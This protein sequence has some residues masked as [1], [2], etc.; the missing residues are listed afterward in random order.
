MSIDRNALDKRDYLLRTNEKLLEDCGCSS[1]QEVE[2]LMARHVKQLNLYN[3][4]K[5]TGMKLVGF[6]AEDEKL[7]VKECAEKYDLDIQD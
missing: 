3:E 2:K 7:D 4:L 5:D 1:I 6:L